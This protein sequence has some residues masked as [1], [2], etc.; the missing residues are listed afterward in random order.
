MDSLNHL[1]L[2]KNH[3]CVKENDVIYEKGQFQGQKGQMGHEN[4]MLGMLK[5]PMGTLHRILQNL[6][7]L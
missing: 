3:E 2:F 7:F 6:Y 4:Y 5:D 1:R